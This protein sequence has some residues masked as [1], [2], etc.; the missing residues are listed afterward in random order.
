MEENRKRAAGY[1][2]T[3]KEEAEFAGKRPRTPVKSPVKEEEEDD[4]LAWLCMDDETVTELSELLDTTETPQPPFKVKF[5]GDPY[6]SSVIFQSSSAYIT[7]NG[8]N[9]ESCGSSFSES[10]SSV[11]ASV[12]MGSFGF[13]LNYGR[14]VPAAGGGAWNATGA[15]EARGLAEGNGEGCLVGG[16]NGGC[17]WVDEHDYDDMLAKFLGE[18]FMESQ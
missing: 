4:M 2:C 5:S 1:F 13:G 8:N 14:R 6:S 17:N 10:E 18:D 11:M 7:I 16:S 15:E 3:E 9:D 12:D